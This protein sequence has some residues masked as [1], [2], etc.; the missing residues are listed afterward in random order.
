MT[1]LSSHRQEVI[2]LAVN[3]GSLVQ[4][5]PGSPFEY[6]NVYETVREGTQ[7]SWQKASGGAQQEGQQHR[8]GG[9]TA[10]MPQSTKAWRKWWSEQTPIN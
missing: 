10:F 8:K 3:P 2:K 1:C 5:V 7:W 9:D 6:G 4:L